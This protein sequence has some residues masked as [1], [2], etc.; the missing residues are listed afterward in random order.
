MSISFNSYFS[1]AFIFSKDLKQVLLKNTCGKL[2]GI[3][4][5]NSKTGIAE[6]ELIVKINQETGLELEPAELRIITSLSN[7]NKEWNI[8]VYMVMTD[9]EKINS[10]K[11]LII[12][13]TNKIEDRCHPNLKWLIPLCLDIS[14]HGSSF[15]QI[16]MK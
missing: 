13:E 10:T 9:I 1:L 6:Q 4:V 3:L 11:D 14:I 5:E 16:L 12:M 7:M 2:D 15:N 8:N